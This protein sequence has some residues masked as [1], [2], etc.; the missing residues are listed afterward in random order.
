ME[1]AYTQR[2]TWHG[3]WKYI[4]SPGGIDELYDLAADPYER[5]NLVVDP[6]HRARL[7]EMCKRMWRRMRAIGDTSL[8][9]SHY[10][11]LR[12]APVGPYAAE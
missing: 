9:E 4:F 7:D 3:N 8:L 6:Q 5:C 12:L 2:I 10:P 1:S 11:T